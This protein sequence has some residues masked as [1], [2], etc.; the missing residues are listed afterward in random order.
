MAKGMNPAHLQALA[1]KV[2]QTLAEQ[3]QYKAAGLMLRASTMIGDAERPAVIVQYA[4]TARAETETD[5]QEPITHFINRCS[6][7]YGISM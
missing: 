4:I 5:Y 3:T 6:E 2:A 1:L 7:T